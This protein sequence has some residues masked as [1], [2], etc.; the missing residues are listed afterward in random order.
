MLKVAIIGTG[1][2]GFDLL[3]K[4][5]N[6]SFVEIVAFVGRRPSTKM[7]QNFMS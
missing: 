6:L 5:K 1:Q 4:I 3:Y 7:L 2:I